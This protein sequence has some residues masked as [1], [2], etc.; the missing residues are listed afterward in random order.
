MRLLFTVCLCHCII[1]IEQGDNFSE[2][3]ELLPLSHHDFLS[4]HEPT[5]F[6]F[7]KV[8]GAGASAAGLNPAALKGPSSTGG[9]GL[10]KLGVPMSVCKC[11]G[12]QGKET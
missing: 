12:P 5:G 2:M 10:M 1:V 4:S 8:F 6:M 9:P 3:L 11:P 7:S